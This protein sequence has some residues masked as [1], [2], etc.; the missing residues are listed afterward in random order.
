[1]SAAGRTR[2]FDGAATTSGLPQTTDFTSP[3]RLAGVCAMCGRLR[4]SKDFLPVL[5]HWSVQPCV[6][7]LS[8][9]HMSAGHNA[10]RGPGPGQ[11]AAFD[12]AMARV[13]CPDRRIDRL[14]ITCCRPPNLHHAGYLVRYLSRRKCDRLFVALAS[15]HHGPDHPSYLVGKRDGCQLGRLPR[16]QCREPRPMLGTTASLFDHLLTRRMR[17]SMPHSCRGRPSCLAGA[18]ADAKARETGIRRALRWSCGAF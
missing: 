2:H 4:V 7:P 1:M 14:C 3:A 16:Q 13:G 17:H 18:R 9:V 10:L 12:N 5:Q 15:S 6:R 11:Q 8:A